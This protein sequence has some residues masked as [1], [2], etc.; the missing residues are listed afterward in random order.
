MPSALGVVG[1]APRPGPAERP[2]SRPNIQIDK[3][4]TNR[5]EICHRDGTISRYA[6][7]MKDTISDELEEG[8]AVSCGQRLALVGSSGRSSAPHLHFDV[9]LLDP[10]TGERFYVDPFAADDDESLWLDQTD[11]PGQLPSASCE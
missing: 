3:D 7:V 1:A 10:E 5:I 2:E 6:H 8:S 11:D 9:K 4:D